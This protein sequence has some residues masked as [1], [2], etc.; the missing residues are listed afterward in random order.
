MLKI[1]RLVSVGDGFKTPWLSIS[2]WLFLEL[3]KGLELAILVL[4]LKFLGFRYLWHLLYPL[5]LAL[6]WLPLCANEQERRRQENVLVDIYVLH[7][8]FFA[9]LI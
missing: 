9:D 2:H 8:T 3:G 7:T 1:L 5:V 4:C 6:G